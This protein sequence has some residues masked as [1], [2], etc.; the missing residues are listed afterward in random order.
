MNQINPKAVVQQ[1]SLQENDFKLK[2]PFSMSI[3]GASQ[4]GKSELIAEFVRHKSLIFDKN[5]ERIIYCQP[6]GLAHRPNR[7]FDQIKTD[8]PTAELVSGLPDV[9]K[10][11]LDLDS[12]SCLVIIDD[13]MND[14]LNSQDM[15][16]L[17]TVYV[18]HHNISVIFTLQNYFCTSKYGKTLMRNVNVKVFF[19]N[20]L[21]L[22]ELR[23]ISAQIVPKSPQFL[24]SCF[25]FLFEKFPND[26][27]HYVLID[28]HYRSSTPNLFV[29]SRI[30]PDKDGSTRPIIFFPK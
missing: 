3:S 29:R 4:S 20:R 13:Q 25:K 26:P 23:N 9:S 15:I 7:I 22:T 11:Y 28:G 19:Y 5:F 30:F 2:T 12:T 16:T 18:H 17:L 27:S 24:E 14:F 1:I 10:L 21:D 6:E 8:F